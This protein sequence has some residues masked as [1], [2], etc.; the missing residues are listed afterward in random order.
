MDGC[1]GAAAAGDVGHVGAAAQHTGAGLDSIGKGLLC[2]GGVLAFAL[3][4]QCVVA[5]VFG[6][7]QCFRVARVRLHDV[8]GVSCWSGLTSG[9]AAA[10]M[11]IHV[12]SRVVDVVGAVIGGRFVLYVQALAGAVGLVSGVH[13]LNPEGRVL[14]G[15]GPSKASSQHAVCA[16]GGWFHDVVLDG[17]AGGDGED[18]EGH[19]V[20]S[21]WVST[22][23]AAVASRVDAS[24]A[25]AGLAESHVLSDASD[26]ACGAVDG[27]PGVAGFVVSGS[28]QG[29]FENGRWQI[30]VVA[31]VGAWIEPVLVGWFARPFRGAGD[32]VDGFLL[33]G[34]E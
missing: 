26:V 19:V 17:H 10:H 25:C 31:A 20:G 29:Q 32:A 3:N 4:A 12:F 13:G 27:K 34:S 9:G 2:G 8:H 7:M 14:S 21:V 22:V 24:V 11:I 1:R 23:G 33:K 18:V 15:I 5:R 28:G 30:V 6:L 16:E